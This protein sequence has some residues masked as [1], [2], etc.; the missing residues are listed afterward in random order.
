MRRKEVSVIFWLVL[1]VSIGPTAV[2]QQAGRIQSMKLLAQNTGWAA[3]SGK[4]S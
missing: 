1:A 2:A 3:E 4:L